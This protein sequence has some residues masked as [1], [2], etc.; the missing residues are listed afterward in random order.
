[1]GIYDRDYERDFD[2][3]G[4]RWQ[5]GGFDMG[6]RRSANTNL[7]LTLVAVYVCQFV[8][9]PWFTSYLVLP[10]DWYLAPW[11]VYGLVT[12][13]LLHDTSSIGHILFNGIALF[14]F[15][16]AIEARYGSREYISFFLAGVIVAGLIWTVT[17]ALTP[18]PGAVLLGA[19]GGIAAVLLLFALNY[20]NQQVYIWGVL[21]VPAWLIAVLFVGGDLFGAMNR[22]NASN[23]AYTAHL[24]GALF[25]FLYFRNRWTLAQWLPGSGFKMPSLKR[26]PKLKIHR[27]EPASEKSDE[28]VDEILRKIQE[29]GQESLTAKEQKILQQASQRYQRRNR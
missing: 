29:E 17:E 3:G 6:A 24:G 16:R 1:M 20:P 18:G 26:R 23:V 5:G 9:Q 15:G 14:F 4:N 7:L 27:E 19:S 8:F 2:Q 28:Q 13:G 25:G 21:P 22:E 11:R 12:Y 10:S